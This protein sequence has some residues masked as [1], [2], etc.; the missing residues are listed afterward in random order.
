MMNQ[1]NIE[2][3]SE[4]ELKQEKEILSR[5][6]CSGEATVEEANRLNEIRNALNIINGAKNGSNQNSWVKSI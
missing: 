1:K 5:R 2:K 4:N 3:M 6:I